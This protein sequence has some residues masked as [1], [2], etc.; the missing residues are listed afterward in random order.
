M[1][2]ELKKFYRNFVAFY[3]KKKSKNFVAFYKKNSKRPKFLNVLN[4]GTISESDT[5]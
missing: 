2:R 5:C 4:A 3:K 1:R